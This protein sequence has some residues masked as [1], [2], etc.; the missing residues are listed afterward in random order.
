MKTLETLARRKVDKKI[1]KVVITNGENKDEY[2]KVMKK[3]YNDGE[4]WV[5][6]SIYSG[7]CIEDHTEK[8]FNEY[9]ELLTELEIDAIKYNL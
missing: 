1:Y 6:F 8:E 9:Y 7:C 3:W 5:A 4:K 2:E